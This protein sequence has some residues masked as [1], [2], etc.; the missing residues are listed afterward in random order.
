MSDWSLLSLNVIVVLLFFN[1]SDDF[2]FPG[3][4]F[5]Q[6]VLI[7]LNIVNFMLFYRTL[8]TNEF[9]AIVAVHV[10]LNSRMS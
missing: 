10:T 8:G 2:F 9:I 7:N 3:E 1:K 6:V 4:A 5:I